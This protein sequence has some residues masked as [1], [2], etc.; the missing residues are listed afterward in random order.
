MREEEDPDA[1]SREAGSRHGLIIDDYRLM[2]EFFWTGL[3]G[4]NRRGA[5]NAESVF[6]Y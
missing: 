6:F 5:E 1:G 4:F 3:F 2:I